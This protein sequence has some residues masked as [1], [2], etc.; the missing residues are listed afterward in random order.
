MKFYILTLLVFLVA[1]TGKSATKTEL[2]TELVHRNRAYTWFI[3][4]YKEGLQKVYGKSLNT[5]KIIEQ[6]LTKHEIEIKNRLV[7][8]YEQNLTKGEMLALTMPLS[9]L[10][11][12]ELARL[13]SLISVSRFLTF[14]SDIAKSIG[15]PVIAKLDV[16]TWAGTDKVVTTSSASAKSLT[17]R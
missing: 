16:Y 10:K 6:E 14:N 12:R 8:F 11:P 2:A 13:R 7:K 5:A 1:T 17:M 3:N 15:M 4:G 9:I